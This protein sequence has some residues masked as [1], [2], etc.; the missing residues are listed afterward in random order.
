MGAFVTAA[1]AKRNRF[2]CGAV[3]LVADCSAALPFLTA[4][5]LQQV[6]DVGRGRQGVQSKISLQPLSDG[7]ADRSTGLAVEGIGWD[8][9]HDKI[10]LRFQKVAIG[11]SSRECVIGFPREDRM[12]SLIVKIS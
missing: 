10:N 4:H 6:L 5:G 9:G 12:Q 11:L 3:G 2:I 8:S 1:G 7:V